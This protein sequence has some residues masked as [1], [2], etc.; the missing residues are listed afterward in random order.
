MRCAASWKKRSGW[1]TPVIGPQ[2][3]HRLHI[4]P[5]LNG[6]FDGQRERI[7]L[8]RSERSSPRRNCRGSR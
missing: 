2:I 5:F 3:W 1:S 4:V 7:Y 8:V 6:Q